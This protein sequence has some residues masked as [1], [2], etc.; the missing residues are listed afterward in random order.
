MGSRLEGLG[1]TEESSPPLPG[2][3][4]RVGSKMSVSFLEFM[5]VSSNMCTYCI[6]CTSDF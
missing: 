1:G 6:Q 3:K 2:V 4:E 5:S